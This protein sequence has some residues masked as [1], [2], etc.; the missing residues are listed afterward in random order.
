MA[1]DAVA[2]ETP[3]S[4]A[5]WLNVAARS[6]EAD[7][8]GRAPRGLIAPVRPSS[9]VLSL[10]VGTVAAAGLRSR[11]CEATRSA[12]AECL[13]G[14]VDPS[15]GVRQAT[16]RPG[17]GSTHCV[18]IGHTRLLCADVQRCSHLSGVVADRGGRA[19]HTAPELFV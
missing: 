1:R 17:R 10:S 3:A 7:D 8:D 11:R 6:S 15:E 18:E 9:P 4:W 13:E 16:R 19:D 2:S 5:T 14:A 12:E